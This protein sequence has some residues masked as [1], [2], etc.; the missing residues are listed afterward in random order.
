MLLSSLTV[1]LNSNVGTLVIE[2]IKVIPPD[3]RPTLQ[4]GFYWSSKQYTSMYLVFRTPAEIDNE[5]R[6]IQ[7]IPREE[8]VNAANALIKTWGTMKHDEL[9]KET[10][11]LF[12][13]N[14]LGPTLKNVMKDHLRDFK[15]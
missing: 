9:M 7:E 4:N 10:A 5:P 8:I 13:F 1:L 14:R 6:T 12:G 3:K 11:K 15:E 2:C